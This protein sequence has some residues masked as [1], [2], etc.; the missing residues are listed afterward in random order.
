MAD[1]YN[2]PY[3]PPAF[4]QGQSAD[5]IHSRMLDSLPADMDKSE[6][7]LSWDFT[8]PAALEKAEFVEF[9]LNEAIKLI[10]P[11]WS[12]GEWLDLHGEKVNT[13]RREANHASGTLKVT[14]T[15]GTVIPKGYQF[16][17]PA[18][19]TASILFETLEETRLE[20]EPD[21]KGQ[22]ACEIAVRAAEGGLTG[23]VP[24][25]T[26]KLMAKP[27]GGVAYVTNPRPI[28]RKSVV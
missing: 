13:I 6:A 16:A 21:G 28:D 1:Q 5:E 25:D 14:G 2:Y 27:I 24:E 9:E 18:N 26:V 15:A 23:N 3:E 11:Q 19:L 7:S 12:Y 22:V 20:G 8:R 10:F 17:T 4:L